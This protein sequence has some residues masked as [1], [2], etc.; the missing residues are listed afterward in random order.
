MI[1]VS[2]DGPNVNPKYLKLLKKSPPVDSHSLLECGTCSL[3]VICGS[4]K[5]GDEKSNGNFLIAAYY[6]FNDSPI[7]KSIFL[8][9]NNV[10]QSEFPL[11][12]CS[13]RWVE[14]GRAASRAIQLIPKLKKIIIE[15]VC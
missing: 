6:V 8:S 13:T 3:H 1:Q 7:R 9:C 11:K 4:I 14:N 12:F 15:E 10:E 5:A 2:M